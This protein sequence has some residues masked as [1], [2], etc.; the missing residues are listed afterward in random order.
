M[1]ALQ[2]DFVAGQ[3]HANPWDHRANE[4]ETEWPPSPWRLL[5]AIVAG[6]HRSGASDRETLLRVLDALV[7]C[8]LFDLPFGSSGHTRHSV[9]LG[10]SKAGKPER[11]LML[12][13]FIAL[14]RDREHAI[15]AFAIW[16]SVALDADERRVLETCCAAICYFGGAESGCEVAVVSEISSAG[17]RFRVD[18]ASRDSGDGPV[19]RRLAASPSLRGSGLLRELDALTGDMRRSRRTMPLGTT[20]VEYRM[21]LDFGWVPEQ[22]LQR[23]VL[24]PVLPATILRFA[25]EAKN[26]AFPAFT[27]ALTVAEKM[28]QARAQ[29]S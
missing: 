29:T 7:E 4:G 13:S 3:F 8:P 1:I 21:P 27:D 12:D 9:P 6:W 15:R 10:E 2:I 22:A 14:E 18:L 16:P 5:R 24:R 11:T 23:D 28:R 17:G 19:V 26:G 25:L 20:W